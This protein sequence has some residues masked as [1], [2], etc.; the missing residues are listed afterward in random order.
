M[1][2][3]KRPIDFCCRLVWPLHP[4][5]CHLRQASCISRVPTQHFTF[6]CVLGLTS[7]KQYQR[8][9]LDGQ[10]MGKHERLLEP[11]DGQS[12]AAD[13][14]CT[15]PVFVNLPR[16]TRNRFPEWQNRFL[17]SLNVYKYGLCTYESTYAGFTSFPA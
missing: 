11:K 7:K 3:Y 13:L 1:E 2:I 6:G 8:I 15:G 17:G 16:S 5:S 12:V 14:L 10:T 4:L 9:Q